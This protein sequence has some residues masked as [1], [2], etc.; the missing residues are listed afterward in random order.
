MRIA[1]RQHNRGFGIL[2]TL[3]VMLLVGVVLGIVARGYQTLS[4]LNLATYQMSQRMEL[5]AFLQRLTYEVASALSITV[6]TGSLDFYRI[7]PTLNL[8]YNQPAPARLPWPIPP[9]A[10]SSGLLNP[11]YQKRTRYELLAASK[12]IRRTAF[13]VSDIVAVNIG[14]FTPTLESGGLVLAVTM[15]P[16]EMTAPVKA[17]VLL[18]VVTP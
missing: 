4:R 9:A 13:G 18:P 8:Q 17:R 6:S 14:E 7:D 15:R 16:G 3:M 10:T 2:E 5:T 11:T 12:E 1:K